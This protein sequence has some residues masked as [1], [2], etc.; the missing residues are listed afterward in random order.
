MESFKISSDVFPCVSV[1]MYD[2]ILYL[3][4]ERGYSYHE[5]IWS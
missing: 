3:D 4:G 2:S 5:K 1:G